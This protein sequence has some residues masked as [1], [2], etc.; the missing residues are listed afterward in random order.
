MTQ[1]NVR[2]DAAVKSAGDAVF[3]QAGYT[4][5]QIVRLLREYEA[6]HKSVPPLISRIRTNSEAIRQAGAR[7]AH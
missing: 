1:M 5:T 6:R 2:M 7:R 3:E 4:L